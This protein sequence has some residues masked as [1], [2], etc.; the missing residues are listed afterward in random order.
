MENKLITNHVE[1]VLRIMHLKSEKFSQEEEIQH[2]FKELVYTLNPAT[3]LK[4]LAGDEDVK[5]GLAKAGLSLGSN[6]VIDKVLGRNRSIRGFLFSVL[7]E[8]IST[9]VIN[10]S[11]VISKIGNL[12]VRKPSQKSIHR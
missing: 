8:K 5:S 1:L 7:V 9:L 3:I 6:Y 2:R 10:N 11:G 12:F 4:N